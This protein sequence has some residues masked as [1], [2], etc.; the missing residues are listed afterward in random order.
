MWKRK[1]LITDDSKL[2]HR[3]FQCPVVDTE[4]DGFWRIYYSFRDGNNRSHTTFFDVEPGYPENILDISYSFILEHGNLG[5]VDT[6]GA[7]ATS[8]M[9]VD[10]TKF[11]YYIGWSRRTDVP[12]FNTTCLATHKIGDDKDWGDKNGITPIFKKYGPILSPDHID[13]GYSGTMRPFYDD[14]T[15]MFYGFYLSCSDWINID[16]LQEPI[17]D[18]KR[19]R[20]LDGWNWTKENLTIVPLEEG[21]GGISS[22]NVVQFGPNDYKMWYSVRGKDNFRRGIK[23]EKTYRIKYSESDWINNWSRG[24]DES[25]FLLPTCDP[26]DWDGVMTCYPYIIKHENT[27]F[28]FYNGNR[29]GESGIGYATYEY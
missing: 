5:Q 29:F 12:Y 23:E 8:I 1:G 20:S 24:A 9:T 26:W 19:A 3:R 17:Y 25:L 18:I 16:N 13:A 2:R 4:N 21:E 7:M 27:L 28:M 22:A 11:L 14:E 15:N 10:D 6:H